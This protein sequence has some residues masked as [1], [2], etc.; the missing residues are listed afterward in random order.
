MN[1]KATD[2]N[3]YISAGQDNKSMQHIAM[4][5]SL[6]IP[7][8][9]LTAGDEHAGGS[10]LSGMSHLALIKATKEKNCGKC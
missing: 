5:P 9:D 2:I 6:R 10:H 3:G 8:I 1:I 4:P 7:P